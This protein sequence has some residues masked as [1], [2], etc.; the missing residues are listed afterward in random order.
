M[1]YT[2]KNHLHL[3]R[4]PEKLLIVREITYKL[5]N[6]LH[7]ETTPIIVRKTHLYFEQSPIYLENKHI[8]Q[9]M[10]LYHDIS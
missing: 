3:E 4:T 6:P 1:T 5:N 8:V 2:L 9:N 7:L 10:L